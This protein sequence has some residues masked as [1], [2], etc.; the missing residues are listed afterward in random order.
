MAAVTIDANLF[1]L[2]GYGVRITYSKS[3]ITGDPRFSYTDKD[4]SLNFSGSEIR[5][6]GSDEIGDL[7]T[8]T[9]EAISDLRTVTVSLLVPEFNLSEESRQSSF[10][11]EAI[12]VTSHTSLGGTGLVQGQ[13]KSYKAVALTGTAQQVD[14]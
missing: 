10:E 5:V 4:R 2:E 9:I 13:L 12:F 1:E 3:S 14:F 8:V 11:T 7:I 6:Q